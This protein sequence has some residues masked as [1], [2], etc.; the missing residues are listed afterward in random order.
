M[1][2]PNFHPNLTFWARP[3]GST[4]VCISAILRLEKDFL[5]QTLK[6]NFHVRLCCAFLSVLVSENAWPKRTEKRKTK[7][8]RNTVAANAIAGAV[9]L[10]RTALSLNDIYSNL[11]HIQR[12]VDTNKSSLLL[13]NYF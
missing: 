1:I 6:V 5:I 12:L 7:F 8:Y 10:V 13:K 9:T 11:M 2:E 3:E 4:S